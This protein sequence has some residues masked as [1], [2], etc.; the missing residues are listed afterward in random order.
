M[1]LGFLEL[2]LRPCTT[3]H[4]FRPAMLAAKAV[5]FVKP[6]MVLPGDTHERRNAGI[7]LARIRFPEQ[8]LV[9]A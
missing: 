7:F 8:K 5:L 9:R 2:A 1:P 4:N 3:T 6:K